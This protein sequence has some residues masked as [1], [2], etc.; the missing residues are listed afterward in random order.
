M[1]VHRESDLQFRAD[2]IDT[3]DQDRVA[4]SGKARA[5]QSA[6]PAD[7]SEHL[8]PM[9]LPNERSNAALQFVSQIDIYARTWIRFSHGHT[10]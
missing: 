2:A 7:F 5:K 10:L 8:R 9:R 6:E 3:G 1:L 4:H